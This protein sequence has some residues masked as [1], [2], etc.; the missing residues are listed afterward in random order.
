MS[1]LKRDGNTAENDILEKADV[2]KLN[3]AFD[4]LAAPEASF[5]K[6][7]NMTRD[8]AAAPAEKRLRTHRMTR[9]AFL[10]CAALSVAAVGTVAYA[11]ASTG[12]FQTAFGD[13]GQQDLAAYE[14]ESKL[15]YTQ[16]MPARQWADVDLDEAQR[17]VGDYVEEIDKSV[18]FAGYTLTIGS[19]VVDENGLAVAGFELENP[20]GVPVSDDGLAGAYGYLSFEATSDIAMIEAADPSGEHRA[21]TVALVDR[22]ASTETRVV[23]SLYFDMGARSGMSVE[24][25]VAWYLLPRDGAAETGACD[26][27]SFTPT[28]LL[29]V[30]ALATEDGGVTASISALGLVL[31]T[32]DDAGR[33]LTMADAATGEDLQV[34]APEWVT[35]AIRV[36]FSDA[37]EY[38]VRDGETTNTA[39]GSLA[40]D[41]SSQSVIF[42]RLIDP[43]DVASVTVN[44]PDLGDPDIVLLP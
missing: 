23:G 27:I 20:D 19:C 36:T 26:K 33:Q 10:A 32:P 14:A 41:F 24:D 11:A 29:P 30:R 39:G 38:V 42:N 13:K 17:L 44:A 12:F 1:A 2:E 7:M 22:D 15:G 4:L 40:E 9:R 35:Q 31:N 25:G 18:S 6:V 21:E 28:K 16:I 43:A 3:R 34:T 5:D 37:S 8:N